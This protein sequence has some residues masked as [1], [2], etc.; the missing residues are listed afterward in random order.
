MKRII[1]FF[2]VTIFS[3]LGADGGS[4][5]GLD[6]SPGTSYNRIN[7]E[8]VQDSGNYVNGGFIVSYPASGV[9]FIQNPRVWASVELNV[10]SSLTDPYVAVVTANSTTSATIKVYQISAGGVITE[11]AN[12][13]VI[14]NF[15][16]IEVIQPNPV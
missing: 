3:S 15:L 7:L 6:F 16:A 12:D 1:T 13:E 5:I 4:I 11:A 2:C 10:N 9:T 8:T 14:V